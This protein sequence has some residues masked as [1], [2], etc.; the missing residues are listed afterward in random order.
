MFY[1]MGI[2]AHSVSPSE[3]LSEIS[4]LYRAVLLTSPDGIPEPSEYFERLRRY[5]ALP[6]FGISSQGIAGLDACFPEGSYSS[7]VA[8]EIAAHLASHGMSAPGIYRLSG[9]EASADAP[10][11]TY[12]GSTLSLTKTECMI[13]RCLIASYPRAATPRDILK[14]AFKPSRKPEAASVRT[15]I[16]VM[17]KKFTKATGRALTFPATGGGY[18][19]ATPEM[20]EKSLI[21][22]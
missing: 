22:V 12:L 11:V 4:T 16:S 14:Y 13:L 9:I 15:H 21:T 6:I 5:C 8:S 7:T 3:A 17:N 1:Y 2:L 10:E 20:I 18:L 19:L